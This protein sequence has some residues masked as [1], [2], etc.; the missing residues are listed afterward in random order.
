MKGLA[1]LACLCLLSSAVYAYEPEPVVYVGASYSHLEYSE[2]SIEADLSSVGVTFGALINENFAL[3]LR[4]AQ[5]FDDET[6]MNI[7]TLELDHMVS[8]YLRAGMPV[9]ERLYPYLVVGRS[10][11]EMKASGAGLSISGKKSDISYG[12]G[13]NISWPESPVI[14]NMEYTQFVDKDYFEIAGLT[15]GLQL[16]Y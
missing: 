14:V 8:G 13:L 4:Y 15:I 2:S 1:P 5:G 9:T 3:E 11:V 6:V 12:L 7:A 10:K 16:E